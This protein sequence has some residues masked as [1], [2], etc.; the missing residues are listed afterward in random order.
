M[1]AQVRRAQSFTLVFAAFATLCPASSPADEIALEE[2]EVTGSRIARRDFTS[3]SPIVSLTTEAFVESGSISIERTLAR[4]P[5]FVPTATSTTNDP[6]NDGQA[7]LSLRGIGTAQTLVLVDGKRLMPADGRGSVD[8]NVLPPTLVESVE[9]M[10]G[11]ASAAY[12]S[13]AIAGVVNFRL[14][15]DVDGVE[16]DGSLSESD[17]G[18]ALEYSAGVLAGTSFAGGRGRVTAY[19][20]YAE[21]EQ[22]N[23]GDRPYAKYPYLYYPDETDGYGPGGAFLAGGSGLT[24]D[25]Y[26]VIFSNPVVF[27]QLFASYGFPPGTAPYYPGVGVNA[28]GTVFTYGDD[29]TPGSVVNYRGEIDPAFV[30]D[31]LLTY[32]T[33]PLTALQLPLERTS[34]FLRGRYEAGPAAEAYVQA[35]YADYTTT[36]QLSPADSDILLVPMSNPYIPPDLRTLAQS[37]VNPDVPFRF[38]ARPSVLGPR[39]ARNDREML[40]VTLGVRGEAFAGWRY[41]VYAQ[42]GRNERTE[43]QDGITRSSKYQELLNAADGGQSI[44]GG[45][46]V[47]GKG[48][49]SAECAAY[50]AT[51]AANVAQVDQAVAEASLNGPLLELPAGPLG[52]AVGMFY[53]RDEFEYVPDPVLAAVVP[54]VPGV[55]GPRPDVSGL[56][57]GAARSGHESNTDLYTELRVP[58]L[59]DTEA[60]RVLELGGG[61]RFSR[62]QQAGR[63]DSYKLELTFRQDAALMWRGSLHSA[64]R[65]PSVEEL[66][67][68][69]IA[70][71]FVVPRPDPCSVSSPQRNGPDQQQVE[72]LCVAQGLPASLLPTYNFDLR[73]VDGVSGGNPRLE[74]ESADTLTAGLVLDST[75]AHRAL[76]D[77]RIAIDWYRIELIDGIGRWDTESSVERC[78]DPA[79]NR[80]YDPS[81]AYCTFFTRVATTGEMYA[82]E[83]D[84]NI[85]GVDTS[86]L[87]LQVDW[88]MEA[89]PGR[90]AV[91]GFMTYVID[92]NATEPDGREVDYAGTIGNRGLGSSIPR[93]RSV[94]GVRYDWRALSVYTRWQHIDA[95]RDAEYRDFRVPARDYFDAGVTATFDSGALAGLAA[96]AGVENLLDEEPPLFPSYSQANTDPSQYDVLGRRYFLN[97]R[98]RL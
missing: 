51:S 65:A 82:L 38:F 56:G 18:D 4:L 31:R 77:L 59:R 37:R 32:N 79:F 73:R 92:W 70:D 1:S 78:F 89:G 50:V 40:Q 34:V 55:I 23:Q 42:S 81:Y 13:D 68:P 19:L 86:G 33:A 80:N 12:G 63:A 97:L 75:L 22:V 15:D 8:L 26:A 91:D 54:G 57:A 36:R 2:I 52:A 43:W 41:D 20:G 24:E 6:S 66:Y 46:N 7:N 45:L 49:I 64:V 96:T 9:V 48:N 85:G 76:A 87:D 93:W 69:E 30:N 61:Y 74:P 3:A 29:E 28:D 90:V 62:Y 95:M 17:R 10:T 25:G 14:R 16:L 98:Y 11:G 44:C 53:K 47:F 60:G 58:L 94:V 5:Q 72:A 35:I 83:L 67:Y 21:R 88:G 71:Q 39:T 27:Q 84:R